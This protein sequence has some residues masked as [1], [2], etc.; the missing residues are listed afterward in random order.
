[1]TQQQ[2]ILEGPYRSRI[3]SRELPPLAPDE[4]RVETTLAA[5]K[6]GTEGHAIRGNHPFETRVF[7]EHLRYF[8][9][10]RSTDPAIY[11]CA[12]GNMVVGVVTQVGSD[13][14]DFR[15]GDRVYLWG[16]IASVHQ[17]KASR[18]SLLGMLTEEQ[19][20]CIDPFC[21]AL[22]AVY[23]ADE[24]LAGKTVLVTGPGAIG[25]GVVQLAKHAGATVVAASSLPDRLAL[26]RRLGA[27]DVIDTRKT[28]NVGEWVK[29]CTGR[30]CDVA[31]EC[32]GRYRQL[33][34]AL[35]ATCQCGTVVTVGFY[36][37]GAADVR[38]GEDFFHNRL[39]L[40]ASLPAVRWGNPVRGTPPRTYD[41][42]RR[43]VVSRF[44]TGTLSAEGF[45]H[46]VVPFARATEA[47]AL[48]ADRPAETI[49]VGVRF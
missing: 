7:D 48:V 1:M 20:V 30:G 38:L 34:E 45:L 3:V 16:P 5:F 13:V 11:P 29:T 15:L 49:K 43:E 4:V 41:D 39:R 37:G 25:L 21:F 36:A 12:L 17:V 46:P 32:S 27:D 9:D 28:P 10:R 22:G 19:A 23:D 6:H 18:V 24:P 2:L 42:L 31:F 14:R 33:D 35:K 8:R 40:L 47:V 44:A 26:A